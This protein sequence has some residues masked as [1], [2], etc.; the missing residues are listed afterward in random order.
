MEEELHIPYSG[1]VLCLLLDK[2]I[3]YFKE[4]VNR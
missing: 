3:F 1:K 4:V 2:D